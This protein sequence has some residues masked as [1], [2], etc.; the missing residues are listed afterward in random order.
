M[1]QNYIRCE[2]VRATRRYNDFVEREGYGVHLSNGDVIW[3]PKEDFE[4][5]FF[6][7]EANPDLKSAVSISKKMVEDFVKETEVI[8]LGDKTTLVRVTLV[9]GFEILEASSCVDA[10]NYSQEIG[11]KIC[12]EKIRD[13]IWSYL[14][15]IL[16]TAVNGV[17][18]GAK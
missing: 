15:F 7:L 8:T 9:N 2:L 13:K 5:Q 18:G 1:M 12:L 14:G 4:K 10:E 3:M 16:Q 17:E 6:P 11:A